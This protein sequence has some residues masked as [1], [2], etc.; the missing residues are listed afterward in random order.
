MVY[1]YD[2]M[3]PTELKIQPTIHL[4]SKAVFGSGLYSSLLRKCIVGC[5]LNSVWLIVTRE[6]SCR[7]IF[8]SNT[9]FIE[10]FDLSHVIL[11]NQGHK[12]LIWLDASETL[13]LFLLNV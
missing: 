4:Q 9:V 8:L 3:S 6:I 2:P 10:R 7:Y 1:A 12:D 11:H 5:I 13:W